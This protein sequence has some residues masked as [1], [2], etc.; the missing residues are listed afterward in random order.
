M[1]TLTTLREEGHALYS[2]VIQQIYDLRGITVS[3]KEPVQSCELC[4]GPMRV[5]KTVR[6]EGRTMARCSLSPCLFQ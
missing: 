5:Q 3:E 2:R 4:Q 6:H 1:K